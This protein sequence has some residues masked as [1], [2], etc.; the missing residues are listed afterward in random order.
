[1]AAESDWEYFRGYSDQG[2]A[3]VVA[4]Q[5]ELEGVPTQLQERN[6]LSGA[7]PEY[8][9]VVPCDLAHRA[10]WIVAQLPMDDAE[11]TYLAT[12]RLGGV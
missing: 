12:K 4:N 3:R 11:L 2:S 10:R 8:W 1:V 9:I 5:L 6:P 7:A